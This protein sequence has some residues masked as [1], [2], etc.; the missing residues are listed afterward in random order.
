MDE[1]PLRTVAF[2]LP[3]FHP[4]PEND[5][6]WGKGFTEWRNVVTARPLFKGHEQPHLPADLGFYDLRVRETREA[7]AE[8]ARSN[9]ITGFCYYHYWF[10]GRRLLNRPFDDVLRTGSPRLPFCLCWA[11]ESWTRTWDRRGDEVLVRQAY[12]DD[13]DAAHIRHL[14]TAFKDERYIKIDGRPVFLVYRTGELPDP[15]KTTRCWRDAARA[16]G[17]PDLYLVSVEGLGQEQDVD[18]SSIG[19]DASVE[20]AP[21][22]N[23]L[24]RLKFQ[25]DR[26]NAKARVYRVLQRAG[27]LS[28]AYA[29]N[30]VFSYCGLRDRML[31]KPAVPHVRFR[32]A[33]PGWDNSARRRTL[34]NVFVGSTP[35]AY[36]LWLE[37]IARDT[38]AA[39]KGGERILFINAWN[40]WA[41]GN[42]LEPGSRWG[43]AYLEAT[44]MALRRACAVPER[45]PSR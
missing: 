1:L 38:L 44:A 29:S 2:Y 9:G 20:F 22:W 14:L 27:L 42:H 18:P 25:E 5:A 12:S 16:E 4:I 23:C 11:N 39:R 31:A 43:H 21:D 30:R 3:Q 37:A 24:P 36:G 13:D 10:N 32:C 8:L 45:E 7:Q 34:A 40:E 6:W 41:E 35:D 26:W 33:T 19:F 17:L 28:D 15:I